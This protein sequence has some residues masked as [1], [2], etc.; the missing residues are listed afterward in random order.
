[1]QAHAER[2]AALRCSDM[3]AMGQSLPAAGAR[4]RESSPLS[5]PAWGQADLALVQP[6]LEVAL[7]QC[8]DYCSACLLVGLSTGSSG[9]KRAKEGGTALGN[10]AG[11]ASGTGYAAGKHSENF[12]LIFA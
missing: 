7:E 11:D 3:L 1:V 5:S 9:G 10:A 4:P 2:A 12:H 8:C 6:L